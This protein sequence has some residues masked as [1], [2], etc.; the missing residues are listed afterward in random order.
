MIEF[1]VGCSGWFYLH[2]N[3]LFYPSNLNKRRWF[4]YYSERFNT[5][6]INSTFYSMPDA[7]RVIKWYKMSPKNFLFSVKANRYI[8]H[9]QKLNDCTDTLNTF[10]GT[11]K[12]LKEKLAFILYQMPPSFKYTDENLEIILNNIPAGGIVEFRHRGWFDMNIIKNIIANGIH[13]ASVSSK[14]LPLI[15][16]DDNIIYFR[17]HGDEN[18]YATDYSSNKLKAF[19]NEIINIKPEK[20]FIYFNNDYNAMAPKNALEML[21][22]ING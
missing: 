14:D 13:V 10:L 2:W 15:F 5:V 17:L 18:G 19:Y 20:A 1:N 11:I 4:E 7:K 9:I 8:T 6:E 16:P 3:S 22:I 12:N 21:N